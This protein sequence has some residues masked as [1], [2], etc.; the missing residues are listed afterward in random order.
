MNLSD[1]ISGDVLGA[2]QTL[3]LSTPRGAFQGRLRIVAALDE[4]QYTRLLRSPVSLS[5][6]GLT[7]GLAGVSEG[8][9]APQ[10]GLSPCIW[11]ALVTAML[12]LAKMLG[13]SRFM[14][15]PA[16][17]N[18]DYPLTTHGTAPSGPAPWPTGTSHCWYCSLFF[19]SCPALARI[20][21]SDAD[22]FLLFEQEEKI[23]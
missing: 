20:I 17:Q 5:L 19:I 11:R 8:G 3:A 22:S 6:E 18:A 1:S 2:P 15:Q 7:L 23:T 14:V 21:S 4:S 9:T 13:S 10:P 16:L 12:F